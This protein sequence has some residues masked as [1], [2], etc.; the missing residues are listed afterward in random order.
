MCS[1]GKKNLKIL[2]ICCDRS[3]GSQRRNLRPVVN[4]FPPY[5]IEFRQYQMV[6]LLRQ[7]IMDGE[8]QDPVLVEALSSTLLLV[9]ERHLC[10]T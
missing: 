9:S 2:F 6:V 7:R 3:K 1:P 5:L 4:W 8:P 10:I